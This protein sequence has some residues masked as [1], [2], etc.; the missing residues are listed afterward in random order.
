MQVKNNLSWKI[1]GAAGFG[2]KSAGQILGKIMMRSGYEVF[3]YTEYPSLIRGGHNTFQL[4]IDPIASNSVTKKIDILVALTQEG[5][6]KHV[7]ELDQAGLIIFDSAKITKKPAGSHLAIDFGGQMANVAAIGATLAV[8]NQDLS[9]ANKVVREIFARKGE[10]VVKQNIQALKSGFD[11]AKK[12]HN[13]LVANLPTIKAKDRVLIAA[14][15]AIALGALASG[16][17]F[18]AAYP[19]TP[20]STILHYLASV[21]QKVGIVVKHAEDEISV[22]NMALGAAHVGARAM[23]GTSGGGFS[24]MV[25][26]LGL[27]GVTETPIV[28]INSM[29]PGPATGMPT[30]TEQGDLQFVLR[31]AQGDF[32]R[33]VLAP[34]DSTESFYLAAEALNLAEIYQLPV[35]ILVDKFIS[36]GDSSVQKFDTKKIKI[37]RGKLLTQAELDKIKNYQRYK[38][39]ADGISPRALP[40][41]SGGLFLANSYEHDTYGFASENAKDRIEQVNKRQQKLDTF[42][43]KMPRPLVYGNPRAKNTVVIWGSTKGPVLDSYYRLSPKQQN[44]IKI[45][46]LQYLW[47]F[48]GQFVGD[49]LRR[50]KKILLIENNN[51]AQLGQLIRQETGI[52]IKDKF[53]KYDGRPFFREELIEKLNGF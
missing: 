26:A 7:G 39:T 22:I 15:E 4:N 21:A 29:R 32:P 42:S 31:A 51:N 48:A 33:I 34:G 16:L 6:D 44:K 11:F 24:L 1:A 20:S 37:N 45:M 19:M 41:M 27:S 9:I 52:E 47:P 5:I 23:V 46:Q 40:G 36:E 38:V 3:D 35:I 14:N 10:E 53:L 8:V 49:I 13:Q 50:S 12:N 30:W 17:N 18:Y 2:I 25:E 43:Q 28:I